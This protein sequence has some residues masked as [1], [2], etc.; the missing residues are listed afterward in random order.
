MLVHGIFKVGV[1][2]DDYEKTLAMLKARGVQ[3]AFGP[4][5][6]RGDQPAN[7]LIRDNASNLI[8]LFAK[9]RE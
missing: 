3:I 4:F 5:P 7:V 9:S 2:I 1:V 6:A 8:Q